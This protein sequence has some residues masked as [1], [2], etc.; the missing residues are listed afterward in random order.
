MKKNRNR[1]F[2]QGC[3]GQRCCLLLLILLFSGP[4]WSQE[5]KEYR[6]SLSVKEMPMIEI[7]KLIEKQVPYEFMYYDG[8]IRKLGSRSFEFKDIL[9]EAALDSCLK[10]SNMKYEL[11]GRNLLFKR[12]ERSTPA[13]GRKVTGVVV[14]HNGNPLPGATIKVVGSVLGRITNK[15]GVFTIIVPEGQECKLEVSFIGFKKQQVSVEGDEPLKIV[16]EELVAEVDEVVVTGY[17]R[18]DKSLSAAST[19]SVKMEDVMVPGSTSVEDMLQGEVPGLMLSYGSGSTSSLP[20]MRMRGTATLLGNA[21]PVWVIDGIIQESP[22]DVSNE[23]VENMLNDA[24]DY[25]MFGGAISGVN[26]MDIESITFLK[27]AAATAIYG[28]RAANGVIVVTTK[29]GNSRKTTISYSGNLKFLERPSYRK[30]ANLMNS[31]QR[32]AI[33]RE[34]FEDGMIFEKLPNY[35]FEKVMIDYLSGNATYEDAEREYKLRERANTDWFDLLFENSISNNHSLSVSGGNE[36]S[37]YYTSVSYSNDRGTQ[38]GDQ[39]TRFTANVRVN[40]QLAKWLKADMKVNYSDRKVKG[41][42]STT[43][44]NY[45]LSTSRTILPDEYYLKD[46]KKLSGTVEEVK[47]EYEYPVTYNYLNELKETSNTGR[48][49]EFSGSMNLALDLYKGVKGEIIFAYMDSRSL[50]IKYASER[51]YYMANKRG[52]DYGA[53]PIG[54]TQEKLSQY[55]YG[56]YYQRRDENMTKWELRGTLRYNKSWQETHT[57]SLLGGGQITSRKSS[58]FTTDEYGYFPDRGHSIFYEYNKDDSGFLGNSYG[59]SSGKYKVT[60]KDRIDNTVKVMASLVYDYKRRY[61]VNASFSVDGTNRF[62]QNKKFRFSPIWS[63]SARW[64]ILEETWMKEQN[65]LSVLNVKASY[66]FQGNVVYGVSPSLKAKYLTGRYAINQYLGEFQLA[67][68]GLPNPNLDWEKTRTINLGLEIAVL[69]NRLSFTAEYYLK[70]GDK[71]LFNREAPLEYGVDKY[72]NYFNDSKLT[73]EGYEFSLRGVAVKTKDVT[74]SISTNISFNRNEIE[75]NIRSES[76]SSYLSGS[77]AYP[78]RP[79]GSFWS[80]NFKGLNKDG[81]PVFDFGE[82]SGYT[83][84]ELRLDAAKYLVYSGSKNPD[85]TGGFNTNLSYKNLSFSAKFSF[86]LG[87]KTRLRP[88]YQGGTSSMDA[89]KVPTFDQNLSSE[90]ITHWRKQGDEAWTDKPGFLGPK[91]M[92][93]NTYTHPGGSRGLFKMWDEGCH[94]VVSADYLRCRSMSLS[95][96]LPRNILSKLGVSSMSVGLTGTNLFVVKDK[97]LKKQ[98]PETGSMNV[99]LLPSYNFSINLNI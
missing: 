92:N 32:M 25:T 96:K 9:M 78:N 54:G 8:D 74:W 22:I 16:L 77:V 6:V 94:R 40:T 18:I 75:R 62:G 61:V 90:F 58:G 97:R 69:K 67:L 31:K 52:Y 37:T 24:G 5:K 68:D 89:A 3:F 29:K 53:V 34:L 48:T 7:L 43:P 27:D 87:A 33:S 14:D 26:P 73:N 76:Y 66:G 1:Q 59:S 80:W 42:F 12:V 15:D 20:K 23:D 55:P 2:W 50:G 95:Y 64:N 93:N 71:V 38:K 83:K 63:A 30:S 28:T 19:Y 91:N 86:A 65:L 79:V 47:V 41:F 45:A 11:I 36:K 10:G 88:V 21:S 49:K 13:V 85:V 60:I 44:M 70:K 57:I 4:V 81:L 35:G 51:S 99:P 84:E 46:V 98:D 56:G 39:S 17:Q 82:N 72:R